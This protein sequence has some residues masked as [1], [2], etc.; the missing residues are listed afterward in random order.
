LFARAAAGVGQ[1]RP[2]HAPVPPRP[3][4]SFK[5]PIRNPDRAAK[6]ARG[7]AG[8]IYFE[9]KAVIVPDRDFE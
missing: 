6:K 7:S 2:G 3:A 5:R 1:R 4:K 9:I 8:L